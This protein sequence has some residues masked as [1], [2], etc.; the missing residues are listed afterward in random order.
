MALIKFSQLQDY[1]QEGDIKEGILSTQEGLHFSDILYMP[2]C[3]SLKIQHIPYQY[4]SDLVNNNIY[5]PPNPKLTHT[6]T[7][8]DLLLIF[9]TNVDLMTIEYCM[10]ASSF[11]GLKAH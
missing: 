2:P 10:L 4:F 11:D 3:H 8:T 7:T 6:S 1:L 9:T 5:T